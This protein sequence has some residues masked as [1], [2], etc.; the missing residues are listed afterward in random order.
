[1]EGQ[2]RGSIIG[3]QMR[4]DAYGQLADSGA[5][6]ILDAVVARIHSQMNSIEE[7][8]AQVESAANRLAFDRSNKAETAGDIR[9][10][11]SGNT[12]EGRLEQIADR[13][14]AL[15]YRVARAAG[16]LNRSV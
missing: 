8:T 15:A 12:H 3:G 9:P 11:P 5:V 4:Q 7:A 6:P 1:M 14:E 16:Q 10:S 13:L 2:L